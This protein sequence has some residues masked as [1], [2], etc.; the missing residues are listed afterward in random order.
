MLSS[1]RYVD[2]KL[3]AARTPGFVGANLANVVNEGD[4]SLPHIGVVCEVMGMDNLKGYQI[5][6]LQ[7]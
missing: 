3:F 2:I 7:D 6:Q 4:T 5:V 1:V